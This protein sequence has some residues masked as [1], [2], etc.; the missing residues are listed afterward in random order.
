[1]S[2]YCRN[3]NTTLEFSAAED[4]ESIGVCEI[5]FVISGYRVPCMFLFRS[6]SV[7]SSVDVLKTAWKWSS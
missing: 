6:N 4:M 7:N 5:P 1:M 2:L 3:A